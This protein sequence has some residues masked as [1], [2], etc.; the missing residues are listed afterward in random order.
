[1]ARMWRQSDSKGGACMA[2]RRQLHEGSL[3]GPQAADLVVL[4]I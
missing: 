2:P 3:C 4:P 1:M